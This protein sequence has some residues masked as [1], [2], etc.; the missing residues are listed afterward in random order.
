[1]RLNWGHEK[2]ENMIREEIIELREE[3]LKEFSAKIVPNIDPDT[4][5]GIRVPVLR[6]YAKELM[7]KRPDEAK[8]F[9]N[10]LPHMYHEENQVHFFMLESIKDYDECMYEIEK[11]LPYVNNWAVTDGHKFKAFKGNE[12]KV[13]EKIKEWVKSE[14]TYTI[15]FGLVTLMNIFLDDLFTIEAN[16]VA[17][18]VRSEEYYVNM[19]QAW[20]FATALAKQYDATIPYI[21]NKRLADWSHNKTIQKARE[22]FR[23]TPEQKEYL[24]SL[25]V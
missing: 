21:E 17:A 12:D 7:K 14:M 13:F 5:L 1:M 20:Y 4:V 2:E 15:R 8:D 6:K 24:K 25:K 10:D 9:L 18:E 16:E 23:I 3:G 19:M 11:F 22:S